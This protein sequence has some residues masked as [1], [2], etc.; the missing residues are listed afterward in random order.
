MYKTNIIFETDVV[1]HIIT[2]VLH[3][4]A[5]AGVSLNSY[6]FIYSFVHFG[7]SLNSVCVFG[8]QLGQ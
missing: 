8:F 2:F 1:V 6:A 3:P 5:N 7:C 4:V